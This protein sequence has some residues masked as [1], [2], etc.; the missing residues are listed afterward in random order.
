[1]CN[2]PSSATE[3]DGALC[4]CLTFT[5]SQLLPD[6]SELR[7]FDEDRLPLPPPPPPVNGV[8]E[9]VDKLFELAGRLVVCPKIDKIRFKHKF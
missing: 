2:L 8:V 9:A 4:C 3:E 5:D 6:F 1:M 7:S